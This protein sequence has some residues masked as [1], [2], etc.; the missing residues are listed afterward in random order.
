MLL[1]MLKSK[2]HK[3]VVTE[4][5]LEYEGSISIDSN[6]MDAARILPY[7][8]VLVANMANGKRFETYAI[9]GAAGSGIIGLNGATTHMGDVGDRVIIF[10]F[11]RMTPE[12]AASY[13]PN[14]VH[15]DPGNK[16]R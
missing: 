10:T 3:A 5:E 8:K 9:R 12:E 14:V 7:E 1:T 15:I 13:Q 11:A 6:L 4:S 16:P 2:I